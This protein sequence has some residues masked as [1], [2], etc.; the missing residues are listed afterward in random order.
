LLSPSPWLSRLTGEE[1]SEMSFPSAGRVLIVDNDTRVGRRLKG[2]LEQERYQVRVA[3]GTDEALVNSALQISLEFRPHVAIVDLRISGSPALDMLRSTDNRGLELLRALS[4]ARCILRSA[5]L[6]P[7]VTR[8][9]LKQYD[10][11]DV[12][13]A[14]E[15]PERLLNVVEA[16]AKD[17]C[18]RRRGFGIKWPQA[19]EPQRVVETLFDRAKQVPSDMVEDVISCAFRESR[20]IRL[21]T[22]EGVKITPEPVARGRSVV[23]KAWP[24]DKKE[25]LVVKLAP[26]RRIAQEAQNYFNHIKGNL[27]GNF[28]AILQGEPVTFWE[29]GGVLYSFVGSPRQ[30]LPSFATFYRE[31]Q[32]PQA[33][34]RPLRHFFIEVWGDL[35][36]EPSQ[37]CQPL[38]SAYNN[39]LRLEKRLGDCV[40][41]ENMTLPGLDARLV[42]PVAWVLQHKGDS[43]IPCT[44]QAITHGD[45]HGDNLFVDGTHTWAIDFERSGPGPVLRDFVELEVDIVTR[46]VQFPEDDLSL[47]D[48]LAKVL[49]EPTEA[50]SPFCPTPN[51]MADAETRKALGVIAGLRE[52]AR[53]VTHY[54]DAREYLWG[55]LLDALFVAKLIPPPSPQRDR[56]LLLGAVLCERLGS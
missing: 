14:Q 53:E 10:A 41:E 51:L 20:G 28:N 55:L 45:L 11:F 8:V 40:P 15:S 32:E 46:L 27:R 23:L 12:I 30:T 1:E 56:A 34:L 4:Q 33:I 50:A 5:F 42:N 29:L 48:E 36:Q 25:P 9:A 44:H 35:Y 39:V 31:R 7:E 2:I 16:A 22:L 26:A 17:S 24:V 47:F 19:W 13:G 18:A 49:A 52:I 38:F 3:E 37:D 6:T 43:T 54:T 21:E